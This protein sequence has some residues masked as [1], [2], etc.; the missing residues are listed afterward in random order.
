MKPMQDESLHSWIYRCLLVN[1]VVDFSCI[2]DQSGLWCTNLD[3]PIKF[4]QCFT[5][6][7]DAELLELFLK[8]SLS[9]E[10]KKID[11]PWVVASN[12][13]AKLINE[14]SIKAKRRNISV[15]Y[16]AAC[17]KESI[18]REGFGYFKS[19]W[20]FY[21]HCHKHNTLL[22]SLSSKSRA[23][24]LK[25]IRG[26]LSGRSS[27]KLLETTNQY[28]IPIPSLNFKTS[29][30]MPCLVEALYNSLDSA[31][32]EEI[33]KRESNSQSKFQSDYLTDDI[34]FANKLFFYY[35]VIEFI[36][37]FFNSGEAE[38]SALLKEISEN[39]I[40]KFGINYER[41]LSTKLVKRKSYNC[42]K[43]WKWA[44]MD[45]CPTNPIIYISKLDSQYNKFNPYLSVNDN[46][47]SS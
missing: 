6:P 38:V 34:I 3:F 5:F 21:R 22:Y 15:R 1:G 40:Y 4:K 29:Y 44:F 27:G 13:K 11:E 2:I 36:S 23:Q 33:N 43:C 32:V 47:T 18:K 10:Y 14:D 24:S 35:K 31:R 45:L 12:I 39:I 9:F 17:I 7:T 19:D 46:L 37:E 16:C 8:S 25:L 41:S 28:K 30:L 26:L 42:T 20:F